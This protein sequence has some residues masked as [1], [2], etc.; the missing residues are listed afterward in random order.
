VGTLDITAAIVQTLIYKGN[1]IRLFQFIAS[2]VFGTGSF[3]GG[4]PFAFYGLIFHYGIAFCW[5]VIFFVAY[6]RVKFLSE[7]KI[8]AGLCYGLFVWLIM[9]RVVLPLSNIPPRAFELTRAALA[10]LILIAAIGLPLSFLAASFYSKKKTGPNEFIDSMIF[11]ILMLLVHKG[12]AL[13]SLSAARLAIIAVITYQSL[14][15]ALIFIRP[16]LDPY[17]HPISEW[18]IGSHGWIMIIGVPCLSV[19]LRIIVCCHKTS[20]NEWPWK[21]WSG[22]APDL[23]YLHSRRGGVRSGSNE[24]CN[25][26]EPSSHCTLR[27]RHT[28]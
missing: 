12:N 5:T 26:P 19:E 24:N 11:R 13:T 27:Y 21:S 15:V 28:S 17:R 9:N 6:P 16:D 23:C 20:Y 8:V 3:S 18:A 1:I 4:L 22:H 25:R 7:N 10:A 2:G 14:L